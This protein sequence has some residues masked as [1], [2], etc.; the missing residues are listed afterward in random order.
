MSYTGCPDSPTTWINHV[1]GVIFLLA[2]IGVVAIGLYGNI[3]GILPL[4]PVMLISLWMA[5]CFTVRKKEK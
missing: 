3:L 1:F 4:L 2:F 5:T